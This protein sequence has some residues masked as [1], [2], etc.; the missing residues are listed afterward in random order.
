M[1]AIA[2]GCDYN[3]KTP[4]SVDLADKVWSLVMANSAPS[5]AICLLDFEGHGARFEVLS[6]S[7]AEQ[8]AVTYVNGDRHHYRRR[9]NSIE[10]IFSDLHYKYVIILSHPKDYE[11]IVRYVANHFIG[12][13][14]PILPFVSAGGE[15][16]ALVE[17]GIAAPT[18]IVVLSFPGCGS[19]RLMP[20]F[21]ALMGLF[22]IEQIHYVSPNSNRRYIRGRAD[23]DRL[24]TGA[25]PQDERFI[26]A[27]INLDYVQRVVAN[28]DDHTWIDFHTFLTSHFLSRLPD[29]KIVH[30][31]RDPRDW[32]TTCCLRWIKD[33]VPGQ[34]ASEASDK[35]AVFHKLLE[36][37][38]Y[39]HPQR[40]Y[41]HRAASF[42]EIAESF[43][44]IQ[45]YD[46]VYGIRFEDIRY[47]PRE[48]YRDLLAWLGL[49]RVNLVPVSDQ[50][51]D[52][53]IQ[54]GTFAH[55]SNGSYVEGKEDATSI[56]DDGSP[57]VTTSMRKGIKG[58]WKN[59]FNPNIVD[60]VK[61]IAGE[62]LIA[63]GY[64]RDLNW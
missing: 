28:M 56:Y 51:L 11:Y 31:Y 14:M 50:A 5:D 34:G 59:H 55:Q 12:A 27:D 54:L 62:S 58:D 21:R 41:F 48:T 49:D 8:R 4:F 3:A 45:D 16:P 25:G 33:S 19:N 32:L 20:V 1:Q 29:A 60:R 53:I 6:K 61:R 2:A 37:A 9:W 46:N 7:H 26:E 57:M 10:T 43:R 63:M 39:L 17:I 52:R 64:E 36:G 18:P 24:K 15:N 13:P 30:L 40:D 23:L 47:N 22:A 42:A 38:D 44:A 35:E